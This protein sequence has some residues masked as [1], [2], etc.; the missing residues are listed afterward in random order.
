[1]GVE[2][3]NLSRS[4]LFLSGVEFVLSGDELDLDLPSGLSCDE[5][6]NLSWNSPVLALSNNE[7]VLDGVVDGESLGEFL[8]SVDRSVYEVALGSSPVI[9]SMPLVGDLVRLGE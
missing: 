5:G 2:V 4:G 7:L 8:P 9:L 1:M 6:L 3:E